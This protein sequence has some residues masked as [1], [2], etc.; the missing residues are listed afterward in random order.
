[1]EK[2]FKGDKMKYGNIELNVGQKVILTYAISGINTTP[3][4][5]KRKSEVMGIYP[6]FVLF[7]S[8]NGLKHS[9]THIEVDK[10][11][12]SGKIILL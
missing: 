8:V 2:E 11:L 6:H 4:I 12:K 9:Y 7:K 1:M 5:K 3:D 10:M